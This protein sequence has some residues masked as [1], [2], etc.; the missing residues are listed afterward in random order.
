MSGSRSSW[1]RSYDA[2][3]GRFFAAVYDRMLAETE[4]AGLRDRRHELITGA[5]GRTLELGAGTGLNLAHYPAAVT[6]LVLTEPF[7]PMARRLRERVADSPRDAEVIV[8]GAELLPF[9]DASFDTVISTLVLCTVDDV[10]AALAEIDRVLRPGG[11]LLF[12]EHVRSRD[13]ALARWQDRLER[14]WRFIG[15]GCRANRDT[16]ASLAASPLSLDR[17]E[18]GSLP[19][20]VPIV[21]PLAVGAAIAGTA[22]A[23]RVAADRPT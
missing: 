8:A 7:E 22:G 4:D 6:E 1:K 18:R 16:V 17:V 5:R 3:W 10:P 13:P 9:P 11:R 14:P 19:K 2:T 20:A 12:C 23:G 21:R 15:H